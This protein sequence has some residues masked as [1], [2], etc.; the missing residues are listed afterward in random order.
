VPRADR[1]RITVFARD[2]TVIWEA[3]T[4][5]TVIALPELVRRT[6]IDTILW[7]VQ[8]HVGW[9]DRWAASDLAVLTMS[10]ARR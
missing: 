1:Y 2:G 7:R 4:R 10:G 8:A 9:E 5:D 6:P 3:Q